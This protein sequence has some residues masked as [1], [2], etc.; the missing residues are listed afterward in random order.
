MIL[1]Q[2]S[3]MEIH[4]VDLIWDASITSAPGVEGLAKS[5]ADGKSK[6][7]RIAYYNHRAIAIDALDM[8]QFEIE[9]WPEQFVLWDI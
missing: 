5:K 9:F 1:Q 2:K 4:A 6:P 7:D 3:W 8:G